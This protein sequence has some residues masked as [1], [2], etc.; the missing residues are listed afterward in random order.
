MS[1][2]TARLKTQVTEN[3]KRAED[4]TAGDRFRFFC[5]DSF[6]TVASVTTT[7]D[8]VTVTTVREFFA[9]ATFDFDASDL[10][11]LSCLRVSQG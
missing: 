11:E 9:G 7:G 3:V 6:R 1:V 2:T 5:E 10:V 8:C 4:L